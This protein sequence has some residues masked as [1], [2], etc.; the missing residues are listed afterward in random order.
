MAKLAPTVP[1]GPGAYSVVSYGDG[2]CLK[3]FPG[4]SQSWIFRYYFDG[5]R[6]YASIGPSIRI[7]QSQARKVV[8]SYRNLVN[9]G[10][11]P[12][13]SDLRPSYQIKCEDCGLPI[14]VMSGHKGGLK[15]C[16]NCAELRKT[17]RQ[18]RKIYN[19]YIPRPI[20]ILVCECGKSFERKHGCQIHCS[21]ECRIKKCNRRIRRN[22]NISD[23][24]KARSN[25]IRQYK[26][27]TD[28]EFRRK[29]V[30]M[31]LENERNLD[32]I[33]NVI[34]EA[35]P[36]LFPEFG[37]THMSFEE[38]FI[39]KSYRNFSN[40]FGKRH[41]AMKL[42]NRSYIDIARAWGVTSIRQKIINPQLIEENEF[43]H[44]F[45]K[46]L[47]QELSKI[48]GK[49]KRGERRNLRRKIAREAIK[50]FPMLKLTGDIYN[51]TDTRA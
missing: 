11:D 22:R 31:K 43:L 40:I 5:I 16:G 37:K 21:A 46:G 23:K 1:L 7:S 20:K 13:E 38:V 45:F 32:A 6:K 26:Y 15:F 50:Q 19:Y 35:N 47:V 4:G 44:N 41:Y 49:A 18:R 51:G 17:D 28:D 33:A 48:V 9:S 14:S 8:N 24:S 10:I 2:L 36:N 12:I 42:R 34:I 27:E 39:I 25:S 29:A 3:T 30:L